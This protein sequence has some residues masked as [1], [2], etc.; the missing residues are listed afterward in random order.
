MIAVLWV[1]F[2]YIVSVKTELKDRTIIIAAGFECCIVGCG[3]SWVEQYFGI[4]RYKGVCVYVD[5]R[6]FKDDK[7]KIGTVLKSIVQSVHSSRRGVVEEKGKISVLFH[8]CKDNV[9]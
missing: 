9:Q 7:K 6:Q 4:L 3:F 5:F 8:I 2:K 1:S